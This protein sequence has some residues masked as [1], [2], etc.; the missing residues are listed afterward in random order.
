MF[1]SSFQVREDFLQLLLDVQNDIQ[2]QN[3]NTATLG[4]KHPKLDIFMVADETDHDLTPTPDH[5]NLNGKGIHFPHKFNLSP[6]IY[7]HIFFYQN[8]L[9]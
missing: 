2:D 8:Y 1:L 3:N 6:N 9:L 7:I 5:K 4:E